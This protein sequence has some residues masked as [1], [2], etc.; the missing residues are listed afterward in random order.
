MHPQPA[1]LPL[2][3]AAAALRATVVGLHAQRNDAFPESRH[4]PAI[5]YGAT[6]PPTWPRLT[7]G[8]RGPRLADIRAGRGYRR[9]CST[10]RHHPPRRRWSTRTPAAGVAHLRRPTRAAIYFNDNVSVALF[11]ARRFEW[12]PRIR[13]WARSSTSWRRPRARRR[14]FNRS[15][16]CLSCH[17]SWD[18]RAVPGSFVMT[19]FPRRASRLRQR[20]HHRLT[21]AARAALRRLVCDRRPGCRPGTWATSPLV[22]PHAAPPEQ[23]AAAAGLHHAGRRWSVRDLRTT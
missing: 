5:R 17:L 1:F 4:H 10:P 9:R 21:R 19:T 20:R 2:V 7:P 15:E 16:T 12:P 18:T 11:A 13:A 3:A 23:H 8:S 6:A 14:G 22:G